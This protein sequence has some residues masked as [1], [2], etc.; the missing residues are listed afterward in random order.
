MGM[1]DEIMALGRV[2]DAFL[3]TGRH[4]RVV[5]RNG[6]PRHFGALWDGQPG[7]DRTATLSIKDAPGC[8]PYINRW[9]GRQIVFN[10]FSVMDAP[11][12]IIVPS[13]LKAW[14]ADRI[15]FD[16]VVIQPTVKPGA[17]RGK[18]WGFDNWQ[19]VARR[20]GMPVVQIGDIAPT[21]LLD[22]AQWI[23]TLTPMHAAAILE[24]AALVLT[25]EGGIHHLA[26]ALR[27][28]AVVV[29]G[30]FISPDVT[31]YDWHENIFA[32]I[33][34]SP[35]GNFEGCRHCVDALKSITPSEVASA[36]NAMLRGQRASVV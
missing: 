20:V 10:R 28:R 22:G 19:S 4:H 15:N 11:A 13:D 34:G 21:R 29:F 14:A 3:K 32:D 33:P 24:R 6:A 30:G 9:Q 36:A 12:T 8:R 35:C 2:Q 7:Y 25:P 27:A 23:Q 17:S 5:D 18:D 1:G 26:G 16:A 31:G